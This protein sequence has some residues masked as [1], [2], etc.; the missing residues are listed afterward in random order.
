MTFYKKNSFYLKYDTQAN[1]TTLLRS[2]N[3]EFTLIKLPFLKEFDIFK[4]DF[5]IQSQQ[6][7]LK[8]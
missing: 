4:D 6:L 3:K 5:S 2:Y 7:T 1:T 8:C